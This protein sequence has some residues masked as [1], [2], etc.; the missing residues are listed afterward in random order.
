MAI[1]G[2]RS[3]HDDDEAP[4]PTPVAGFWTWWER[5]GRSIDV[6]S[7][8][9][10]HEHLTR[11]VQAAHPDLTWHFGPGRS[12]RHR[13]TVSAG[14]LAE[15]RPAAERW[16]R[17]APPPDLDWEYA[18]SVEPDPAAL[19]QRLDLGG[20]SLDLSEI[21]FDVHVAADDLRV[22]VGVHHPSFTDLPGEV[23]GQV[24]FM[25]LDWL[26]GEDDVERWIGTLEPVTT[27]PAEARSG[28]DLRA[29]VSSLAAHRDPQAWTV[30]SGEDGEGR[31]V[32]AV[33]RRGLRWIDH[34]TFDL[35]HELVLPFEGDDS[36][37]PTAAEADAMDALEVSL[38]DSLGRLAVHLGRVT[39][40]GA[41]RLH[42]YTDREDQNGADL[43]ERWAGEH[44]VALASTLDPA[45]RQVRPFTG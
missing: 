35:H 17:S 3:R 38:V 39:H 40:A 23:T 22:H 12:A 30:L 14:G 1:F 25:V 42:V 45:W 21:R 6:S 9:P 31:P 44:R 7:A 27:P 43:V 4:G 24:A 36:G 11:L 10:E 5:S 13:L 32:L 29:V 16:V 19:R 26:L 8:G 33:F 15:A 20:A 34:P 28:D 2:R 37:Q 41:R 18:S